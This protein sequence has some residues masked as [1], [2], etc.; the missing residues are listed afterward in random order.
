MAARIVALLMSVGLFY[1]AYL[2]GD[3]WFIPFGMGCLMLIV[4]LGSF[5]PEERPQFWLGA[6]VLGTAVMS[7]LGLGALGF[8][9]AVLTPK[10]PLLFWGYLICL[11]AG[12]LYLM[13]HG[14]Q[15]KRKRK[16]RRSGTKSW[17]AR[18]QVESRWRTDCIR[19]LT[20]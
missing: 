11:V 6:A 3:E 5:Y 20:G 9:R 1:L 8:R 19:E 13:W 18:Q 7:G 15:Q 12:G 10:S 14:V 17:Q 4:F 16:G 2:A